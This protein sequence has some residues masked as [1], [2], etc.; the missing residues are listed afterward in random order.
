MRHL[1]INKKKTQSDR[2][3][4]DDASAHGRQLTRLE[5]Q[6]RQDPLNLFVSQ[7]ADI[8][9]HAFHLSRHN[10]EARFKKEKEGCWPVTLSKAIGPAGHD[11]TPRGGV[12]A[13]PMARK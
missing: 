1:D 12:K 7:C 9:F 5:R 3:I 13:T 8:D 6:V 4:Q 2:A 11:G 10:I